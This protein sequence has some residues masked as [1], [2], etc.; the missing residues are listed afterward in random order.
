M[1]GEQYS[2]LLFCKQYIKSLCLGD[3][4]A[5]GSQKK[6]RSE[7]QDPLFRQLMNAMAEL[8]LI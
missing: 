2:R 6:L 3:E 1:G 4:E 7:L 5:Q 8:L